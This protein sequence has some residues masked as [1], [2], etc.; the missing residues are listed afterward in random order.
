LHV[1]TLDKSCSQLVSELYNEFAQQNKLSSATSQKN[2]YYK[3]SVPELV[4]CV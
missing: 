1:K 3:L 4:T 2:E